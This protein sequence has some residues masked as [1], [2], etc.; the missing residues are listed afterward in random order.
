MIC[1]TRAS[2]N[3]MM[4][5]HV[6]LWPNLF[7]PTVPCVCAP[8]WG[9]EGVVVAGWSCPHTETCS[10]WQIKMNSVVFGSGSPFIIFHFAQRA[11]Q[12]SAAACHVKTLYQALTA[13][14]MHT[15]AHTHSTHGSYTLH[16]RSHP[17]LTVLHMWRTYVV[18]CLTTNPLSKTL[19]TLRC[20]LIPSSSHISHLV[21]NQ[22][23]YSSVLPLIWLRS[24]TCL[25][26]HLTFIRKALILRPRSFRGFPYSKVCLQFYSQT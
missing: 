11:S 2:A 7:S 3:M 6:Q 18:I 12:T 24:A 9:I 13:P 21:S 19:C 1:Y 15:H 10:S 14:P 22:S 16:L 25:L 23:S 4:L 5:H 20:F 8:V 26:S 17:P